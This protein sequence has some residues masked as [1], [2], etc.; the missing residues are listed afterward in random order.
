MKWYPVQQTMNA[1][2]EA[3]GQMHFS[4]DLLLCAR[5]NEHVHEMTNMLHH[6]QMPQLLAED[7]P[8]HTAHVAAAS[9][10][11][12]TAVQQLQPG[13]PSLLSCLLHRNTERPTSALMQKAHCM[14]LAKRLTAQYCTTAQSIWT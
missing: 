8:T 1:M 11:E 4:P 7:E 12:H 10:L 2:S 9:I 3:T 5:L 13:A 6:M 14:H